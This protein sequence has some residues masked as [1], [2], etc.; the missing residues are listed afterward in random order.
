MERISTNESALLREKHP[1]APATTEL[2]N[3]YLSHV[4]PMNRILRLVESASPAKGSGKSTSAIEIRTSLC[5]RNIFHYDLKSF[6]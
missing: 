3:R 4:H 6:R 5:L 1:P 2:W